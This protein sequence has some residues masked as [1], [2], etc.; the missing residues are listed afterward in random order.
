MNR[1]LVYLIVLW[2]FRSNDSISISCDGVWYTHDIT[3]FTVAVIELVCCC[4]YYFHLL[5]P[6][7][8]EL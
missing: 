2:D 1:S 5:S 8:I 3:K 7:V 6:P 4:Y